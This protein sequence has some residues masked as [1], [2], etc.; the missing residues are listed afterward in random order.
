M[1]F[2]T[3]RTQVSIRANDVA[4]V[5][6]YIDGISIQNQIKGRICALIPRGESFIVQVDCGGTLLAEI[7]PRACRSLGLREGLDVYCLIK[8]PH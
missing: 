2:D 5:C 7:T 6:R 8:T 3:L 4:L 1:M